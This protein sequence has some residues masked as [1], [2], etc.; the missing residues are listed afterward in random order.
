ML[1]DEEDSPRCPETP[2]MNKIVAGQPQNPVTMVN[3]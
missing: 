1:D 3:A 2:A